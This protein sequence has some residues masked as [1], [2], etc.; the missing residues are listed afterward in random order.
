M[1]KR[2]HPYTRDVRVVLTNGATYSIGM[3]YLKP[4]LKLDADPQSHSAWTSSKSTAIFSEKN[5]TSKFSRRYG[6]L[7]HI[8]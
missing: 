4:Y 1:Y 8:L 2:I 7:S 6:R 5:R 3:S